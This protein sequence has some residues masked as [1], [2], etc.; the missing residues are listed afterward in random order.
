MNI[1][2]AESVALP[3]EQTKIV[4]HL[5]QFLTTLEYPE[6]KVSLYLTDDDEIR[7]LNQQYRDKDKATDVLSWSYWEDDP[8]SEILGELAMSMDRIQ[9]QA[10]TNG[11]S[12]ATEFL[13]LLAHG[14]AHLVGYDHEISE[15]EEQRMLAVEIEMLNGIGLTNIYSE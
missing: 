9:E 12:V 4:E 2:W 7:A 10:Q 11:W 8:A 5:E 13:R 1:S 15:E 14:C 6:R 3:L